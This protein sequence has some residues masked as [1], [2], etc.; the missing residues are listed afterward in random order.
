MDKHTST[1]AVTHTTYRYDKKTGHQY[2][3]CTHC[4][5]RN[6]K[7]FEFPINCLSH[8]LDSVTC[9]CVCVRERER[10]GLVG[11]GSVVRR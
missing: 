10:W 2:L 6:I 4:E 8:V 3:M 7:T 1:H 9:L 5:K 11:G